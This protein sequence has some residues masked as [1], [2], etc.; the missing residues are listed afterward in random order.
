MAA[1]AFAR[2]LGPP[3]TKV[4]P[5]A[6]LHPRAMRAWLPQIGLWVAVVWIV[7]F[8]RLGYLSLLDPDEAHYAQLTREMS[9][10]NQWLVPLLNGRPFI[11]K[12]VLYH[13][14][15]A[16]SVRVFGESEWAW[17][18]PSALAAVGLLVLIRWIASQT[19]VRRTGNDA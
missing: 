16:V 18:L 17:R 4:S 10:A 3:A 7:V 2:L 1:R 6:G 9:R 19:F 15:Q 13:W 11:D 12:P 14:L 5:Q 8:W